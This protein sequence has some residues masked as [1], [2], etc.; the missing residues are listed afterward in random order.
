MRKWASLLWRSRRL[1]IFGPILSLDAVPPALFNWSIVA[2]FAVTLILLAADHPLQAF[3]TA[4]HSPFLDQL[5][6]HWLLDPL[7]WQFAVAACLSAY[8]MIYAKVVTRAKGDSLGA[9]RMALDTWCRIFAASIPFVAMVLMFIIG[10]LVVKPAFA[11]ARPPSPLPEPALTAWVRVLLGR[12]PASSSMDSAPSGFVMRQIGL[13]MITLWTTWTLK[14]TK[15]P[16]VLLIAAAC[17]GLLFVAFSRVY[18]SAHTPLDIALAIAVGTIVCWLAVIP[19]FTLLAVRRTPLSTVHVSMLA[20]GTTITMATVLVFSND[21][22]ALIR[23]YVIG[24]IILG[25]L[26]T[27][28]SSVNIENVRVVPRRL[29]RRIRASETNSP[30]T[31]GV[32]P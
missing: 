14:S 19:P 25:L 2:S 7:L 28:S 26:F 21:P 4:I 31:R 9:G 6:Y 3:V 8:I 22:A 18:R 17:G 29:F 11:I 23:I 20:G 5:T 16:R 27:F 12:D 15:W 24:L 13:L 10:D 30:I 32:A 1:L